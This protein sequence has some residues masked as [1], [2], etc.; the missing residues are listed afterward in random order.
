[1][2]RSAAV[3]LSC[4]LLTLFVPQAAGWGFKGH[5]VIGELA[6]RRLAK[7]HPKVLDEIA[8]LVGPGVRLATLATCAD[9]IRDYA[10][11]REKGIETR[12]FPSS[13]LLTPAEVESRFRKTANWHFINIPVTSNATFD[14][15]CPEDCITRRIDSFTKQLK[16]RNL[17]RKHRAV[18][19]MFLTHLI[20]DVH[21][22]LHAADRNGD[23]GGNQVFVRIGNDTRRL[24][25][26]WDT[27]LV[28]G[29][30]RS[31]LSEQ[32]L[33]SLLSDP[34]FDG[35]IKKSSKSAK[36]WAWE[37]Y[38]IARTTAYQDV[39]MRMTTFE[40]PIVLPDPA[41]RDRATQQIR[42]RLYAAS[43]RLADTLARALGR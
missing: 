19:L 7:K 6:E 37:S 41:Y 1:M 13:C 28:E 15:A 31:L 5:R 14:A 9:E 33:I 23:Q 11:D 34:E 30:G 27:L 25:S 18:A 38:G 2:R 3:A 40:D 26:A 10:R 32:D 8:K 16:D 17:D 21:Q 20:G 43:V 39:P 36:S 22:P 29:S 4:C 42:E 24:H 35:S 12:A